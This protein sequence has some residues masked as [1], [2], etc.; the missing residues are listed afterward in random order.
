MSR[1]YWFDRRYTWLEKD[2]PFPKFGVPVT[3]SALLWSVEL[4]TEISQISDALNSIIPR[5]FEVPEMITISGNTA[6]LWE[7]VDKITE[8]K[9]VH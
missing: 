1:R 5:N 2:F 9:L 6:D 4:S 8:E 3:T 7:E